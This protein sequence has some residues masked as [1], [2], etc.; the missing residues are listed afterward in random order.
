MRVKMDNEVSSGALNSIMKPASNP[1][2]VGN[3]I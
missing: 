2:L 1:K 3:A